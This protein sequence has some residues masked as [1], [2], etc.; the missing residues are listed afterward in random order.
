MASRSPRESEQDRIYRERAAAADR[1]AARERHL[2]QTAHEASEARRRRLVDGLKKIP[3]N[4][5]KEVERGRLVGVSDRNQALALGRTSA[6]SS[7]KKA[8][9]DA[10]KA[11]GILVT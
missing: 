5:N 10:E 2:T 4:W 9:A 1:A 11:G 3:V 8:L 7:L 6:E